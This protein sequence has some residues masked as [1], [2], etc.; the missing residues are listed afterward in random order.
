MAATQAAITV[1]GTYASLGT[2]GAGG[3]LINTQGES[4]IIVA[5]SQPAAGTPGHPLGMSTAPFL[6]PFTSV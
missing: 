5:A 4:M 3:M 6:V 1:D 2:S